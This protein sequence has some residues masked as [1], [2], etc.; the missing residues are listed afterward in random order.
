[1]Y[2]AYNEWKDLLRKSFLRKTERTPP[3]KKL[4]LEVEST[5]EDNALAHTA[6]VRLLVPFDVSETD[7]VKQDWKLTYGL[8]RKELHDSELPETVFKK[9]VGYMSFIGRELVSIY[10]HIL[11]KEIED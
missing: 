7:Q 4:R 9:Y 6:L 1:M 2:N 8:R 5:N 3:A 11:F 10:F